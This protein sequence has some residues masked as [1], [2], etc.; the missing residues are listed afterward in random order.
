M[1]RSPRWAT[2]KDPNDLKSKPRPCNRY[3]MVYRRVNSGRP[4][5]SIWHCMAC[6]RD[7]GKVEALTHE[8]RWERE[9]R[10]WSGRRMPG[11]DEEE[12]R[13]SLLGQVRVWFRGG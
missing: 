12:K 4:V 3:N 7:Y 2:L 9:W 6:K 10:D 5:L 13:P 11:W 1:R 8:C